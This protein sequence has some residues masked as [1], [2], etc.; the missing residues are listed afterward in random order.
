MQLSERRTRIQRKS[1]WRSQA[2]RQEPGQ[3]LSSLELTEQK[4]SLAYNS[5]GHLGLKTSER[6]KIERVDM[7]R[8]LKAFTLIKGTSG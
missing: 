4:H 6:L 3:V 8:K 1:S 5:E 2:G 7:P